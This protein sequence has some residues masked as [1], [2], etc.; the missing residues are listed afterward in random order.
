MQHLKKLGES[1]SWLGWSKHGRDDFE[2]IGFRGLALYANFLSHILR[3]IE[4]EKKVGTKVYLACN[5]RLQLQHLETCYKQ[6][7][8][9][10]L[11]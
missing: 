7:E 10:K 6:L 11:I 1:E 9:E 4:I 8:K 3:A 2:N 5:T